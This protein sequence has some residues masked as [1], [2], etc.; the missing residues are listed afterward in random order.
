MYVDLCGILSEP[1]D[2][3]IVSL[4]GANNP[5]DKTPDNID[6]INTGHIACCLINNTIGISISIAAHDEEKI[7]DNSITATLKIAGK[8]SVIVLCF[9]MNVD[10][11]SIFMLSSMAFEKLPAKI[12]IAIGDAKVF[13][14]SINP[15]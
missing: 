14:D 9:I 11:V 13:I 8:N 7:K 15:L 2:I 4:P 10:I 6:P 1:L 5:P 12:K 3:F